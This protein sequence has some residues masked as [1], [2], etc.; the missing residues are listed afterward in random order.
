MIKRDWP[1]CTDRMSDVLRDL[2]GN[3]GSRGAA[4]PPAG[5]KAETYLPQKMN[6]RNKVEKHARSKLETFFTI[7]RTTFIA[8]DL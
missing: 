5:G 4:A 7:S 3:A 8:K 6:T 1:G 2:R